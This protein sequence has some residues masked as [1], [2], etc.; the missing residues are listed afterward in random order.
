MSCVS[1]ISITPIGESESVSEYVAKAV[2]VIDNEAN[3][4]GFKYE[5]T[6]MG[7]ILE[8]PTIE[9][10]LKVIE[11][12][13]KEVDNYIKSKENKEPRLSILV[14]M[15]IRQGEN[16]IKAIVDSVKNKLNK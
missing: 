3:L 2:N 11:K 7:T 8:T 14:K 4:N 15:D 13:V 1:I 12:A 10:S 16:R 9:D 6:A 5:L